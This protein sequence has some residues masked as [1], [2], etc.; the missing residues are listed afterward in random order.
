MV[1]DPKRPGRM[2]KVKKTIPAYIPEHDALI[3][4][5]VRK[6]AYRLDMSLFNIAGIRFGYESVIGLIPFVGDA[7]GLLFAL[8]LW[9]TANKV[10]GGLD[11]TTSMQMLFNIAVDFLLGITPILGD[12]LDAAFKCNTKNAR[13]LE[14]Y[15]DK[16]HRPRNMGRDERDLV[17]V[18]KERRKKNRQSG[19]Y[20]RN[21]PP[22]A[23][24]FEDFSD[25]EQDRQDFIREGNTAHVQ[26]PQRAAAPQNKRSGGWLDSLRGKQQRP[27]EVARPAARV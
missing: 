15:L 7:I 1:E 14:V 4:A 8:S 20:P 5:K 22:P 17:N 9:K 25:E 23:T 19:I 16:K 18:D 11:T 21:D 13:L 6:S 24:T 2:K 3:L 12:L 10:D 26:A 27:D